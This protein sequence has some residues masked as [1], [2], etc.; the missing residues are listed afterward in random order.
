MND[1]QSGVIED[2]ERALRMLALQI[3]GQLPTNLAEAD[4]TLDLAKALLTDFLHGKP[5]RAR[6][7]L[8][9]VT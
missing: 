3:V 5:D 2:R 1:D 7:P 4:Y 9:I 8:R 6:P